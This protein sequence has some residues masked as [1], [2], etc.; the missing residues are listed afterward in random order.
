MN[1]PV[2]EHHLI[3][4][5]QSL[6]TFLVSHLK[7]SE[8]AKYFLGMGCIYVDGVRTRLEA[9]L[10]AGQVVR[11][12]KNPKQYTWDRKIP[13][14]ERIVFEHDE[15]LVLDK[16]GGL[17]VHAT[18]DNFVDNAKYVLEAELGRELYS[19]HRL[20][21]P[22][23]GLLILAKNKD[24]QA[25]INKIF[26]KRRVEK[27]YHALTAVR[28]PMGEHTLYLNPESRVPRET[29]I[30]A[31]PGW[32][33]C[34]LVIEDVIEHPFGYS[35]RVRLE[36]GKTHQIRAQL[37]SLN[38]PILG[39]DLYGSSKKYV[40]ERLALECFSLSFTYRSRTVTVRRPNSISLT[41]PHS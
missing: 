23:E 11:L 22:T 14:K 35:S 29:S 3:S 36:T 17:P 9:E 5:A 40:H 26:A 38:C 25:L 33:E 34:R 19:T 27:I 13:L 16:P 6:T 39:D 18:L 30:S 41:I 2:I 20:D 28:P 1:R 10:R 24:A 8:Q 21:I 31:Q 15:F 12:H 7:S 32:W 37:A 4:T